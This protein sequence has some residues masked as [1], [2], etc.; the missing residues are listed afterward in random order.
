MFH[1]SLKIGA[2]ATAFGLLVTGCSN[3]SDEG[4]ASEKIE[5]LVPYGPG[6]TPDLLARGVSQG[7]TD[8]YG[9]NVTVTNRAGAAGTIAINETVTAHPDGT[10]IA[11]ATSNSVLWQPVLDDSLK[12]TQETGYTAVAKAGASPF[13]IIIGENSPW[14]S[15]KDF[16]DDAN[17]GEHIKIAVTGA[18][19]QTDLTVDFLN[20]QNNWN[21]ESVPFSDGA[22]EGLL[23]TMRGEADALLST[24]AGVQG[25]IDSGDAR[26]LAVIAD[27]PEPLNPDASTFADFDLQI[28]MATTFYVIVSDEAEDSTV[29]E[30]ADAVEEVVLSDEW[31]EYLEE[32]GLVPGTALGYEDTQ[33]EISD[34][35][36]EYSTLEH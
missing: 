9:T 30:M 10:T 16:I 13:S 24:T 36:E 12:Y 29:E 5:M 15:L 25:Q 2:A 6:G 19:A 35:I 28:P 1:K 11:L 21:L 34:L 18:G 23:A 26:V 22:G 7:L 32:N 20:Q 8:E 31:D 14:E 33:E 17:A 4:W 27:E 3:G